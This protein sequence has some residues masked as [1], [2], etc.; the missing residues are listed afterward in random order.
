MGSAGR[1]EIYSIQVT[2]YVAASGFPGCR[3]ADAYDRSIGWASS[4]P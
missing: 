2:L 3:E 1:F 4:T